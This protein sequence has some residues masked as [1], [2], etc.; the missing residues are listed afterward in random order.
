MSAKDL[1][2]FS[3]VKRINVMANVPPTP[4]V[5]RLRQKDQRGLDS[6]ARDT[7]AADQNVET[8]IPS[9]VMDKTTVPL[10]RTR[11]NATHQKIREI[12]RKSVLMGPL[13]QI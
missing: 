11:T 10:Q 8:A 13:V 12:R 6:G 2:A 4:S 5:M 3:P 9:S 7:S 1:A